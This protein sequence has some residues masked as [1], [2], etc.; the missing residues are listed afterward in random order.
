[1][2][3]HNAFGFP[4]LCDEQNEYYLTQ[5]REIDKLGFAT[6]TTIISL[7]PVLISVQRLP[8]A[9]IHELVLRDYG[10]LAFIIA[11]STFGLPVVQESVGTTVKAADYLKGDLPQKRSF[12]GYLRTRCSK[13]MF[14][15]VF[16]LLQA[17]I[18]VTPAIINHTIKSYVRTLWGCYGSAH[19]A[20]HLGFLL[21]IPFVGIV[22]YF[23]LILTHKKDTRN[24]T[25]GRIV[26]YYRKDW[27]SRLY[28]FMDLLPGLAQMFMTMYFTFLFST[29]YGVSV[30]AAIVRVLMVAIFV[31]FSRTVGL[32][33]ATAA[34]DRE[35]KILVRCESEEEAV[36]V[37]SYWEEQQQ[38]EGQRHQSIRGL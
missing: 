4:T 28:P 12:D 1:M 2:N 11:G 24:G 18:I 33:F 38:Q 32:W 3:S 34:S 9:T 22:W 16:I 17:L 20:W 5:S 6:A 37:L 27:V 35:L 26:A 30:K 31:F 8:T 29:M 19:V 23:F 13:R 15:S 7:V 10:I 36:R 25:R 14:N 21:P